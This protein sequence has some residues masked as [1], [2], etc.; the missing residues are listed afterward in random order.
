VDS[1]HLPTTVIQ[2]Q[3][4]E[5]S[6]DVNDDFLGSL[7]QQRE[8]SARNILHANEVDV[9]GMFEFIGWTDC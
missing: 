4:G 9:K 7:S 6:G 1:I 8:E 3:T 2:L 5:E